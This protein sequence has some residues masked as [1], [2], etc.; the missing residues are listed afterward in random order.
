[1]T[2]KT[3]VLLIAVM[4]IGTI[5]VSMASACDSGCGCTV[6][7]QNEY[8]AARNSPPTLGDIMVAAENGGE[9]DIPEAANCYDDCF[10]LALVAA[11]ECLIIGGDSGICL[12]AA[13]TW[14]YPCIIQCEEACQND[15]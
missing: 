6:C 10:Y 9:V 1:M 5:L 8:N 15:C 11:G 4:F 2:K 7:C 13:V 14:Y 3:I 12:V